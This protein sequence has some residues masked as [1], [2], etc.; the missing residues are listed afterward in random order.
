MILD[1][2][3]SISDALIRAL[4]QVA[5][6]ENKSEPDLGILSVI[7]QADLVMTLWQK[8]LSIALFS[9]AASSVTVRREM[10]I[11]NNHV[12]IRI[13]GKTNELIQKLTDST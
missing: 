9:L 7:R 13:E 1:V 12:V 5:A 8:Y 10:G 3:T 4:T 2:L 6:Y 11:F